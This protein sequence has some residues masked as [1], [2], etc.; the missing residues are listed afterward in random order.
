MTESARKSH[1]M[2]SFTRLAGS[3]HVVTHMHCC[4]KHTRTHT[5]SPGFMSHVSGCHACQKASP[6]RC[7]LWTSSV[8]V[9][10]C[11]ALINPQ[12]SLIMSR[13]ALCVCTSSPSAASV[14]MWQR[15]WAL[16][17]LHAAFLVLDGERHKKRIKNPSNHRGVKYDLNYSGRTRMRSKSGGGFR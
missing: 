6:Y 13:F 12:S 10:P 8:P 2:S 15:I 3:L 5:H 11:N 16:I 9:R 4:T 7:L 14:C 1:T 17:Q